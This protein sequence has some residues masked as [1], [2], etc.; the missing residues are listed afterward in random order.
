MAGAGRA[1]LTTRT[2]RLLAG[3]GLGG[4]VRR[5]R[6]SLLRV[7]LPRIAGWVRLLRRIRLRRV[8]RRIGLRV[9]WRVGLRVLWWIRLPGTRVVL[10]GVRVLG[11]AVVGV[12]W[13]HDRPSSTALRLRD[14]RRVRR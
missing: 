13:W 7:P 12:A 14:S 9:L 10:R 4:V 1:G 2:R 6:G 11:A 3:V 8:L 5:I